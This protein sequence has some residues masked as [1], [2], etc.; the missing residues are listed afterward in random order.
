MSAARMCRIARGVVGVQSTFGDVRCFLGHLQLL[1]SACQ[2]KLWLERLWLV[3]CGFCVTSRRHFCDAS[4]YVGV[5]A[6]HP[7][8]SLFTASSQAEETKQKTRV[9]SFPAAS[10]I[11]HSLISPAAGA[12]FVYF[13]T[14]PHL[15][16]TRLLDC[17]PTET[18][19]ASHRDC[20]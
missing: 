16:S 3:P 8:K 19:F 4:A 11:H 15:D 13:F 18:P 2:D 5:P 10:S 7:T 12:L 20:P 6:Q 1:R 17:L 14:S 9:F